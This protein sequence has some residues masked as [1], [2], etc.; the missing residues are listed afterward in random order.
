MSRPLRIAILHRHFD[1]AGGGAER[2]A[3]A[4]VEQLAQRHEVHVIAQRIAHHHP[5][6]HYHRLPRLN[7][8]RWLNQLLYASLS[9]WVTRKGFDIIHAHENGW[10][11]DVQTFHVRPLRLNLLGELKGARRLLRWVKILTS[12]R[13]MTYLWLEGARIRPC[14]HRAV[15]AVSATLGEEL[16]LSY[17]AVRPFLHIIPP[18]VVLPKTLPDAPKA[19]QSLGLPPHVPLL[20]FIANDYR[21]KG[22]QTVLEALG[23]VVD[24]HL[25]VVG[26]PA[27]AHRFAEHVRTLGL[28]GRVH[29]L[30]RQEDMT[31]VYAA[32]DIL[33]H[34][35]R[36]DSFGMVV[37]EAMAHGRPVIVSRAPWCGVAAE[38]REDEALL[39]SDPSSANELAQAITRLLVDHG[40][41]T[42][43]ASA[44]LAVAQRYSW[45]LIAAR[46]E[47]LYQN[48]GKTPACAS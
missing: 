32:G 17:P 18:G 10:A 15:V 23:Q 42:H 7:K 11:G 48:V 38:L 40:L 22:L 45:P 39:L 28:T 29:F 5:R 16:A 12:L 25:A 13:L 41:R 47:Q 43:L 9:A 37:L 20:L 31:P 24:A 1:P 2:Y 44:G 3:V 36:E 8:P 34:P 30:G 6:V 4:L 19:R 27:Q 46:Y 21:R 26:D 14:P 33:V 35:T